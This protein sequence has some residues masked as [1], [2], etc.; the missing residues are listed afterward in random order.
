MMTAIPLA[1]L[2]LFATLAAGG[3][4]ELLKIMEKKLR[5]T[6]DWTVQQIR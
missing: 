5:S 6:V 3:P 2:L 4:R 1:I